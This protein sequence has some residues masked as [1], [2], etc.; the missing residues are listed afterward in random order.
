MHSPTLII[1][2]HFIF[3]VLSSFQTTRYY[4]TEIKPKNLSETADLGSTQQ[5]GTRQYSLYEVSC[6]LCYLL[7]LLTLTREW[8]FAL[9][10]PQLQIQPAEV[11][12]K[13]LVRCLSVVCFSQDFNT[14]VMFYDVLQSLTSSL[15][16]QPFE[17]QG[18]QIL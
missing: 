16:S 3:S 2:M 14:N 10:Y 11:G 7:L 18:G 1:Y 17:G 13:I 15:Q 8:L 12:R 4:F 9:R 5:Q 6:W